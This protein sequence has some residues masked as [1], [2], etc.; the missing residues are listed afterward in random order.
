MC[1]GQSLLVTP[2]PLALFPKRLTSVYCIKG[3]SLTS[4]FWIGLAN[5]GQLQEMGGQNKKRSY[6]FPWPSHYY[7]VT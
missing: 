3:A 5:V 1:A 7:L 4:G 2:D 6:L